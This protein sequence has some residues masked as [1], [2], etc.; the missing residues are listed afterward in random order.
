LA[1]ACAIRNNLAHQEHALPWTLRL[2]WAAAIES[3][4]ASEPQVFA[5]AALPSSPRALVN[6]AHGAALPEAY[7]II[8]PNEPHISPM[9]TAAIIEILTET[10]RC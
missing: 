6:S 1:L 8:K 2:K 10:G 7:H 4:V 9:A 3:G 5:L